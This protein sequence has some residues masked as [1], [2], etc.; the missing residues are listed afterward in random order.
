MFRVAVFRVGG[1]A[2]AECGGRLARKTCARWVCH[3]HTAAYS[4]LVSRSFSHVPMLNA[5]GAADLCC[6]VMQLLQGCCCRGAWRA[7]Y[8]HG[9]RF[10]AT[11]QIAVS[12]CGHTIRTVQLPWPNANVVS[13][14]YQL[15]HMGSGFMAHRVNRR[16][17]PLRAVQKF[18]EKE[19]ENLCRCCPNWRA[20]CSSHERA[21]ALGGRPQPPGKAGT[22]RGPRLRRATVQSS[23][24]RAA[25][26]HRFLSTP[27][28][29][30][31][32]LLSTY[33]ELPGAWQATQR[34]QEATRIRS[35]PRG[36]LQRPSQ[37]VPMPENESEGLAGSFDQSPSWRAR[38]QPAPQAIRNLLPL[39]A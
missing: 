36:P 12:H 10:R 37:P 17:G 14:A 33:Q 5:R 32:W 28:D 38:P 2:G 25:R 26:G 9:A 21:V 19:L 29:P 16:A 27:P 18:V 3:I 23:T 7:P 24:L 22:G 1:A 4:A 39:R 8:S 31:I 11:A 35:A 34:Q 15:F 20:G 30:A 6:D 13:A